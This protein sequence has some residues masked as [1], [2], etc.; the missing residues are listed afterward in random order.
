M[1]KRKFIIATKKV[2]EPGGS[3]AYAIDCACESFAASSFNSGTQVSASFLLYTSN[4]TW[5]TGWAAVLFSPPISL[6]PQPIHLPFLPLPC[7]HLPLLFR[8]RSRQPMIQTGRL[9]LT[10]RMSQIPPHGR[11]P[12]ILQILSA[13]RIG[14]SIL[15]PHPL[16]PLDGVAAHAYLVQR[17][18]V[19]RLG[20][21][22]QT[23]EWR[24]LPLLDPMDGVFGVE[25]GCDGATEGFHGGDG[26][27][28]GARYD[29]VDRGG[30]LVCAAGQELDAVLGAVDGAGLGEFFD[31]D[32][33]AGIDALLVDP[34]LD[35][36]EVDGGHFFCVAR[37]GAFGVSVL[38]VVCDD[39][40]GKLVHIF[41]A[42]FTMDYWIGSLAT[43][44][45]RGDLAVLLLPFVTSARGFAF[46]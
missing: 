34:V 38:E 40:G 1:T 33:I 16:N 27:G 7:W 14:Q 31:G 44:E 17:R 11:I 35:L 41:E 18:I 30:Q 2:W 3:R 43:I 25:S 42:M 6:S 5:A 21:P 45:S 12:I 8:L 9:P 29:D 32:G 15:E 39:G 46:A 28:R 26:G 22:P 36:V 20:I 37:Y 19:Q 4:R 23:D 13:R 10:N 24:R